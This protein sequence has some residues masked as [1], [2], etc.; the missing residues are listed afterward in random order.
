MA[1]PGALF[2]P[3]IVILDIFSSV[4]IPLTLF[5]TS[6]TVL[7]FNLLSPWLIIVPGTSLILDAT[8]I[9]MLYTNPSSIALGCIFAPKLASSSISSYS[10]ESNLVAFGTCFGFAVKMPSTSVYISHISAF[11]SAAIATAVVSEPPRPS[12]VISIESLKP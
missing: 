12:V 5:L 2:K 9:G 6:P 10:T 7:L 11:N 8:K 1:T 4:A 3:C